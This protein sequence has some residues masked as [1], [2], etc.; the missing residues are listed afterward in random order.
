MTE[1]SRTDTPGPDSAPAGRLRTGAPTDPLRAGVPTDPLQAGVPTDPLQAG[2]PTD[3]LQA[4]V[5]TDR[6]GAG[7]KVI[8]WPTGRR[9]RRRQRRPW[10]VRALPDPPGDDDGGWVA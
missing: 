1:E 2:V 3:P 5:P 6:P 10:I 4:G 9:V 8:P 7:A